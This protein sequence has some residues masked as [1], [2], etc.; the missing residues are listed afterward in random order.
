MHEVLDRQGSLIMLIFPQMSG[1]VLRR[2]LKFFSENTTNR[3]KKA[4]TGYASCQLWPFAGKTG[5]L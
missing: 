2:A 5:G 4:L 3:H 1:Y